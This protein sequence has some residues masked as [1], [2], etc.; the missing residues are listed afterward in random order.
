M[1][2][3]ALSHFRSGGRLLRHNAARAGQ[4]TELVNRMSGIEFAYPTASWTE[5]IEA[6]RLRRVREGT[7][8]HVSHLDLSPARLNACSTLVP[9]E[10]RR[11][12]EMAARS[13]GLEGRTFP[14]IV[15]GPANLQREERDR[16]A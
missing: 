8:E 2:I 14:R 15:R 4:G 16:W 1:R 10:G 13:S 9:I 12:E 6:W 3:P 7:T 5:P 11:P